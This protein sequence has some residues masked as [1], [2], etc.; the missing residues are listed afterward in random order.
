MNR[1][2]QA[3]A[4]SPHRQPARR[5]DRDRGQ[6]GGEA[7]RQ[8]EQERQVG[9]DLVPERKGRCRLLTLPGTTVPCSVELEA[10]H[11]PLLA[12]A[13]EVDL[14]HQDLARR[15]PRTCALLLTITVTGTSESA[16]RLR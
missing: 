13:V 2:A 7:G 15:R 14:A 12:L 1:N 3:T 11:G 9:H 4:P 6:H 16:A 5:P 8:G 10:E